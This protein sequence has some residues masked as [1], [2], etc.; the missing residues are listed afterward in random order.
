VKGR[1]PWGLVAS[2]FLG[3]FNDNALKLLVIVVARRAVEAQPGLDRAGEEAAL[4]AASVWTFGVFT[5]PH[6]PLFAPAG[7]LA[8]RFAKR[9]VI[10]AAKVAEIALLL[11]A[12]ASLFA[13]PTDRVVPL[14]LLGLMGVRHA[15]L[16]PS[17][18]GIVPELVEPGEIPR[19]NA[20]L[21]SWTFF[22][23]IAGAGLGPVLAHAAGAEPGWAAVALAAIGVVGLGAALAIPDGRRGPSVTGWREGLRVAAR[24][25]R[26]NPHLRVVFVGAALFWV[27]ASLLG[28]DFVV[29]AKSVLALPEQEQALPLAVLGLGVG[30]GAFVAGRLSR[31]RIALGLVPLGAVG[32]GTLT[33][34]A[35]LWTP[36]LAVTLVL[37]AALGISGGFVIVPLDSLLQWHAPRGRRGAVI[38]LANLFVFGGM[39]VGFV[40]GGVLSGAGL[41][42][43]AILVGAAIPTLALAGWSF[44]AMRGL[45]G[46]LTPP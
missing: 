37:M 11:L 38:A 3:A 21:E 4:Y 36:G 18:Y 42:A 43:D 28:Q 8:D 33:L 26:E 31:G 19:T 9:T 44:R 1:R 2:Q 10:L 27:I 40:L 6:L 29:Y 13:W 12:A 24:A 35:G 25:A 16:S 20:A 5:L 34:A 41:R 17:K 14:V 45:S 46:D 39:L 7:A 22:G 23:I 15:L 32:V 30:L